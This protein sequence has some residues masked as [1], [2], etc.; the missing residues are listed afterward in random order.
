VV[1]H[2]P[3][4]DPATT[5]ASG[6]EDAPPAGTR[7][8]LDEHVLELEVTVEAQR[9]LLRARRPSDAVDALTSAVHRLGATLVDG[10]ASGAEVLPIDVALGVRPPTLPWAPPDEPA[11]ARL[12]RV[13]PALVDD[14]G[15]IVHRLWLAR[16]HGDTAQLDEL[17]GTLHSGAIGRL[18]GKLEPGDAVLAC[19]LPRAGTLAL[20]GSDTQAELALRNL[21]E[22]LRSELDVDERLGRLD[23]VTLVVAVPHADDERLEQ[24]ID[25]V[26]TRW[27]RER[28]GVPLLT[29]AV[30]V[31]VRAADLAARV[32]DQLDA[33][34]RA[35][36]DGP[37][38][39]DVPDLEVEVHDQQ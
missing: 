34:R 26:A 17:T 6:S 28:P 8:E 23:P 37:P 11:R 4:R 31:V 29:A 39:Q 20:D 33:A 32:E 5:S 14:A 27:E 35:F 16:E 38:P 30:H 21:A 13:L 18:L 3:T 9:R 1:D 12:Q 22:L 24:L 19:T 2:H 15:R 36:P 10:E 7:S 25:R